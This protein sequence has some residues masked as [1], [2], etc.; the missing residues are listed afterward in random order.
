MEKSFVASSLKNDAA[1]YGQLSSKGKYSKTCNS[2]FSWLRISLESF[3]Q[4]APNDY[5]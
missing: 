2:F 1:K 4:T 5:T 3:I